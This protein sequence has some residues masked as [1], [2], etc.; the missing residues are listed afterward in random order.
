MDW[1]LL[2]GWIATVTGVILGIPQAWRIGRTR[3]VEGVSVWTWQTI[4]GINLAW[5]IH[6]LRTG[7]ANL[8]VVNVLSIAVTLTI[9]VLL[10]RGNRRSVAAV[11]APG[12][13][14]GLAMVAVA[15]LLGSEAFGLVAIIPGV[16][17][18]V[19][20]GMELVRA[21]SVEGVSGFFLVLASVN[22]ALW[23]TWG[24]LVGDPAPVITNGVVTVVSL[25]NLALYLS[26]VVRER[27]AAQPASAP[28]GAVAGADA[29]STATRNSDEAEKG[30]RSHVDQRCS[31]ASP[32]AAA[33][34]SK[35]ACA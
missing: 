28:A 26:R 6:G 15:V 1:T 34:A 10:A 9:L 24:F 31:T 3:E 35:S 32:A 18:L 19:T 20:Q 22:F 27:G 23:G 8:I 29:V 7:Q 2:V 14:M 4:L 21:P 33:S 17:G 5:G 12:L 11:L 13:A 25:V 16:W 30:R